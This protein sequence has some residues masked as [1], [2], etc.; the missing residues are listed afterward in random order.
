MTAGVNYQINH[1]YTL[2]AMYTF[3]GSREQLVLS[4]N[5]RFGFKGK[6]LMA[7]VNL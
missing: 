5:Y 6:N 1:R 7:G 4:F 2:M 3:L